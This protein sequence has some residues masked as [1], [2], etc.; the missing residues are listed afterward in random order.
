MNDRWID[1]TEADM[2]AIF[3]RE[4]VLPDGHRERFERRLRWFHAERRGDGRLVTPGAWK[5][6]AGEGDRVFVSQKRAV[7]QRAM[8]RG[9]WMMAAAVF[10]GAAMVVGFV[11]LLNPATEEPVRS[12]LAE[13]RSYYHAQLEEQAGVT[14]CLVRRVEA[15]NR[16]VLLASIEEIEREPVP[17]V[18]IPDEDYIVLIA[19]VYAH[20]MEA[21][22]KIQNI[23]R[24]IPFNT[25]QL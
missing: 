9:G 17:E 13:V 2:E 22:Q 7:A 3:G 23:V 11:W 8:I 10:V 21:L 12:E 16:D 1:R 20:K 6:Q 4:G 24:E 25:K 18:Q 19:R 5:V 15:A 14:K